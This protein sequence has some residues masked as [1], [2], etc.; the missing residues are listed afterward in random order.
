[1]AKYQIKGAEQFRNRSKLLD[2]NS[3]LRADFINL[4]TTELSRLQ[5]KTFDFPVNP[6][7]GYIDASFGNPPIFDGV[8]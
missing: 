2:F 5:N 3:S 8:R 7:D 4:P 6:A 1:M